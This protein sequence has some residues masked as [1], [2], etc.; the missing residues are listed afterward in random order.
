VTA[1]STSHQTKCLINILPVYKTA[2]STDVSKIMMG[3]CGT[4]FGSCLLLSM[5]NIPQFDGILTEADLLTHDSTPISSICG[6]WLES[7]N[8]QFVLTDQEKLRQ[9]LLITPEIWI[10]DIAAKST[11]TAFLVISWQN[12]STILFLLRPPH[13]VFTF[14]SWV[15][16]HSTHCSLL[17]V[18][19]S[20]GSI[21]P[22]SMMDY[23][24][25]GGQP[26]LTPCPLIPCSAP[27]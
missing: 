16:H 7:N 5:P 6:G 14:Y 20:C 26:Y 18:F 9:A 8:I 17:F 22:S 24:R 4:L 21:V 15:H 3:R 2:W 10:P 12:W 19:V 11:S 27:L 13:I 25:R 23:R 1:W